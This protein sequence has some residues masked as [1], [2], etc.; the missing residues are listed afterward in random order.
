MLVFADVLVAKAIT[1]VFVTAVK[2]VITATT[3]EL[4]VATVAVNKYVRNTVH[5][6]AGA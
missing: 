2:I 3:A 4:G 1:T 5:E 6:E